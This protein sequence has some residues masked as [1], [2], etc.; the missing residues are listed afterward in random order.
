MSDDEVLKHYDKMVEIF[1]DALPDPDV[2]PKCFGYFCK[3][4]QRF[5]MEMSD[6]E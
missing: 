2:F 6:V 1:G 4:Y 3:L 5:H